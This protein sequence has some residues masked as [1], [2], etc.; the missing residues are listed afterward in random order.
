[1]ILLCLA[2]HF[3]K[4]LRG[5]QTLDCGFVNEAA[6]TKVKEGAQ[7]DELVYTHRSLSVEHIPQPLLAYANSTS[8]FR[9]GYAP[10]CPGL[11]ER[12]DNGAL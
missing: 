9:V 10:S 6:K 5:A 4:W 3:L 1:M 11:F 2:S 7:L 8:K 12:G